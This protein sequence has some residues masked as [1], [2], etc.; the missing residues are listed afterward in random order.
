MPSRGGN[1]LEAHPTDGSR[2]ETRK[3]RNL[4]DARFGASSGIDRHQLL[5]ADNACESQEPR[6]GAL[7]LRS[8]GRVAK[9]LQARDITVLAVRGG[10]HGSTYLL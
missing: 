4:A 9:A 7:S 10:R 1:E 8:L 3:A 5:S 6:L 2:T